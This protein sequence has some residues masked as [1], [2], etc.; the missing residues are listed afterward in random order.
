MNQQ[1]FPAA[2]AATIHTHNT[3]ETTETIGE[4]T[5]TRTFI[6]AIPSSSDHYCS[7]CLRNPADR[8]Q[9]KTHFIKD[10][11][12]LSQSDNVYITKLHDRALQNRL[13]AVE[14]RDPDISVRFI[15]MVESYYGLEAQVTQPPPQEN[16]HMWPR[17]RRP[18]KADHYCSSC[19][20]NPA[21]REQAKTHFIKD[22]HHLSQSDRNYITK[23]HDRALQNRLLA[24]ED[25]DPDLSVRFIGMVESYYGLEAKVRQT[26]P[27]DLSANGEESKTNLSD[28]LAGAGIGGGPPRPTENEGSSSSEPVRSSET[29][30]LWKQLEGGETSPEDASDHMSCSSDTG[31]TLSKLEALDNNFA[32]FDV[33]SPQ[34][35]E[36][37]RVDE[38]AQETAHA[39][40]S[41]LHAG[42]SAS[43]PA[44]DK[45]GSGDAIEVAILPNTPASL[46]VGEKTASSDPPSAQEEK[47]TTSGESPKKAPPTLT[48]ELKKKLVR[49]V[50]K[51]LIDPVV[52]SH[53]TGVPAKTVRQVVKKAGHM[54]PS[55]RGVTCHTSKCNPQQVTNNTIRVEPALL[56]SPKLQTVLLPGQEIELRPNTGNLPDGQY[57]IEPSMDCKAS[58]NALTWL[59]PNIL[60]VKGPPLC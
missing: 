37:S 32:D 25:R 40:T 38:T 49:M 58:T 41:E 42:Q 18:T 48:E 13:L 44:T 39:G 5:L 53:R 8:E 43:D 1:P 57:A 11:H 29:S 47:A 50:T 33:T 36:D 51:D 2:P 52:V 21:T 34:T 54:L 55:Y 60:E 56:Q 26:S 30:F 45:T 27:D 12:H 35:Q 6:R 19:L 22:C 7:F 28:A 31:S 20:K 59:Q 15:G 9:A 16:L 23:L 3:V 10:C 4:F 46:N 14:E 17:L 24:V